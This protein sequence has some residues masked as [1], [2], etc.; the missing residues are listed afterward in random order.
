MTVDDGSTDNRTL[1]GLM[2]GTTYNISIFAT[3]THFNSDSV[4]FNP[5]ERVER[6][7]TYMC[8]CIYT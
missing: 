4:L 2:N 1:N 8:V 6:K 7:Y 5:V 3:S